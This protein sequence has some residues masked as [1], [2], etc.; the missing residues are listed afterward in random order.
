[1]GGFEKMGYDCYSNGTCRDEPGVVLRKHWRETKIKLII[2]VLETE[3]GFF[4]PS[5]L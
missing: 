4:K 3:G 5:A 2:L 1:M